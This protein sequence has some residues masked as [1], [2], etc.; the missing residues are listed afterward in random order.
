DTRHESV[1][2]VA[3]ALHRH[4]RTSAARPEDR[5][6]RSAEIAKRTE[7]RPRQQA[8][9]GEGRQDNRAQQ[10]ERDPPESSEQLV[11]APITFPHLEKS[12]VQQSGGRDLESFVAAS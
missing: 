6:D 10:Q 11:T 7:S 3:G 8:T 4:P 1:E 12:A 2:R 5:F 9:P